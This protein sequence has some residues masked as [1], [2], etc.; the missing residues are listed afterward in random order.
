MH[1]LSDVSAEGSE[2]VRL[3]AATAVMQS[4]GVCV[5]ISTIIISKSIT[6]AIS[7]NSG[8]FAPYLPLILPQLVQLMDQVDN[9]ESKR[10]IND[11]LNAVIA[12]S[13]DNVRIAL[14]F[15]HHSAQM[16]RFRLRP[17]SKS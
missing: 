8:D 12:A 14:L 6:K 5:L 10:K 9:V 1:L 15:Y 3:T 2:A 11:C 4:V 16:I 7:V 13:Q 17:M